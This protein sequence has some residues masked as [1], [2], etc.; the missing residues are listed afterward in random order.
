MPDS[1]TDFEASF[2]DLR[3]QLSL[4]ISPRLKTRLLGTF[5][6]R[7]LQRENPI[8]NLSYYEELLP[9]LLNLANN[10]NLIYQPLDI[11]AALYCTL[12]GY[13]F[14][15]KSDAQSSLYIESLNAS[16][17]QLIA[18][19]FHLGEYFSGLTIALEMNPCDLVEEDLEAVS[20][21][22][23]LIAALTQQNASPE[24]ISTVKCARL[25]FD[26]QISGYSNQEV[27]IPLIE[28]FTDNNGVEIAV[29]TLHRLELELELR[30]ANRNRDTLVF[31][32]HPIARND[33]VNYQAQDALRA[34][35]HQHNFLQ[36]SRS[37]HYTV[38]FGFPESDHLYT[39]PVLGWE[40]L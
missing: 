11:I 15:D 29:G 39:V 14:E 35:R 24:L 40:W 22:N 36:N 28:R 13:E 23:E 12:N 8:L 17:S 33:L 6:H 16:R 4:N 21:L 10:Q 7:L 38:R 5:C 19:Y 37:P 3:F 30:Q 32:N 26:K 27:W 31:N 18:S 20:S 25:E 34:A 9:E 2:Q 1:L